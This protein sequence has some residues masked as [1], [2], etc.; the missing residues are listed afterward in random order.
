MTD[1]DWESLPPATVSRNGTFD[2]E[3]YVLA[4]CLMDHGES[5]SHVSQLAST[6]F[7]DWRNGLIFSTLR[8]MREASQ[9]IDL[10]TLAEEL[11]P[12]LS[13]VGGIQA[14]MGLDD[15]I[16]FA[17]TA[18]LA[19]Y[20]QRILQDSANRREVSKAKQLLERAE[21]GEDVGEVAKQ[22]HSD[23]LPKL[24]V[25]IANAPS[26]PVVR[27]FLAGKP[28]ATPGN[29]QTLISRAKT[30]KTATI[31]GV[32]AAIVASHHD[33]SG[34]D[35]LGFTAPHTRE[36]VVLIDTEQSPYDA[37]TCHQRALNRAQEPADP[38]WLHHYA[39]VG[40]G[41]KELRDMLVAALTKAKSD[42]GGIFMTIL[43]GVADFVQSVNDEAE[44]NDFQTWLRALSITY[45]CPI[46]CVI[47]SNE[48]VQSGDDGRGHLGKQL[49]RKAESNL[50]LKKE[51]GVTTIT[52]EKQRKAPITEED[53]VSFQW[54][55]SAG[56][57]VSCKLPEK[58]S[59]APT[60]HRF[61]D[62]L[63]IMPTDKLKAKRFTELYRAANTKRPIPN[64]SFWSLLEAASVN[65]EVLVDKTNINE[66]KYYV[67]PPPSV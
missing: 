8:R 40:Y 13:D 48:A 28:I 39:M 61:I 21:R 57:H 62:Y 65:G 16:R 25:S 2:P 10:S 56:R 24:R 63:S 60:K 29:I 6:D 19:K 59:G 41:V 50:L 45:N 55:D 58:K 5:L 15:P 23:L 11:G 53:G 49:T 3:S 37:F 20:T 46:L 14:L 9:P 52:S 31:G 44:C 51:N 43:D 12:R 66:P 42:H 27:L 67:D 38:E 34:L 26:E 22:N 4:C 1:D 36:A 18:H 30:G 35:T 47:H 54:S 33:R 64:R 7:R 32:I 17:T